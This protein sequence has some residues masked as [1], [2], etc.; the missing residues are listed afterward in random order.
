MSVR[1][2][3]VE[4]IPITSMPSVVHHTRDSLRKAV[5]EA[6]EAGVGGVTILGTPVE[7][8]AEGTRASTRTAC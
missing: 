1:E 7:Y 8:D 5:V 3:A 4:P 2:G 6:T